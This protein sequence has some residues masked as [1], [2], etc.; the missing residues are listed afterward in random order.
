MFSEFADNI[1]GDDFWEIVI[2][3]FT[4][5]NGVTVELSVIPPFFRRI[6]KPPDPKTN[7][8]VLED[9]VETNQV[10]QDFPLDEISLF[11]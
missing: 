1:Y 8:T 2:K 11:A 4:A 10:Y 6:P 7:Y 5:V 9:P 3:I